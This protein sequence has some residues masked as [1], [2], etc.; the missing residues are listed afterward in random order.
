MNRS[1]K[2]ADAVLAAGRPMRPYT[3][4]EGLNEKDSHET[5]RLAGH[6]IRSLGNRGVRG[7]DAVKPRLKP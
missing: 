6:C 4:G 5:G 3:P 7:T 2:S 1:E